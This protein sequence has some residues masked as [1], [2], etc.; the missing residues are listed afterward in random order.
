[1]S[2]DG[3][4]ISKVLVLVNLTY[5]YRKDLLHSSWRSLSKVDF[6]IGPH[7]HQQKS[8]STGNAAVSDYPQVAYW[9]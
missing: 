1:M 4:E 2:Q 7:C 3:S 5:T 8:Y 6:E 9:P